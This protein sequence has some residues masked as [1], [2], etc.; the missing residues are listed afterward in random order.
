MTRHLSDEALLDLAEGGVS[1]REHLDACAMCR[2]RVRA[3]RETIGVLQE[4]HIPEPSPLF[5]EHFS[6][7]VTQAVDEDPAGAHARWAMPRWTWT[8]AAVAG[9]IVAVLVVMPLRTPRMETVTDESAATRPTQV[10]PRSNDSAADVGWAL[11]ETDASWQMVEGV[12]ADLDLETAS[13]AGIFVRPGSVERE[14]LMLSE[15]DRLEFTRVIQAELDR[16]RL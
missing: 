15:Q 11:A 8:L 1:G 7:R 14:V 13:D 12:A 6:E 5:W 10:T 4:D 3:V 9:A 16:S 2:G